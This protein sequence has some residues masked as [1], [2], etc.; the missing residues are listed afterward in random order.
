MDMDA[1]KVVSQKVAKKKEIFSDS[2]PSRLP[3]RQFFTA[4]KAPEQ[5]QT[6]S[7]PLVFRKRT[8]TIRKTIAAGLIGLTLASS[9]PQ[10]AYAGRQD[11]KSKIT[12]NELVSPEPT[13]APAATTAV[14]VYPIIG[15]TLFTFG[16]GPSDPNPIKC[17]A[18]DLL[19]G[20]GVDSFTPG[21][22]AFDCSAEKQVSFYILVPNSTGVI[23]FRILD[24]HD[25]GSGNFKYDIAQS[26]TL[27]KQVY[28]TDDLFYT[29]FSNNYVALCTG[30]TVNVLTYAGIAGANIDSDLTGIGIP[31]SKKFGKDYVVEISYDEK[32]KMVYFDFKV[33]SKYVLSY[34]IDPSDIKKPVEQV[35]PPDISSDGPVGKK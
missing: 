10:F 7:S 17:D 22:V 20:I 16:A 18:T 21:S 23:I 27:L 26:A 1:G 13:N 9:V 24:Y 30:R 11:E 6:E 33:G 3:Q 32:T 35:T 15:S 19:Q 34:Q 8:G 25:L 28:S 12:K 14:G 2:V 29:R 31:P 5:V 4:P